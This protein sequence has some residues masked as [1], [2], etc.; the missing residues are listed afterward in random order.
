MAL[1]ELGVMLT[2]KAMIE[3]TRGIDPMER[4]LLS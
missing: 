4:P 3:K 2:R 1:E